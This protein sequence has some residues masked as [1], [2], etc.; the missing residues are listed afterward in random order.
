MTTQYSASRDSRRSAALRAREADQRAT[1][2]LAAIVATRT[3][4]R[5]G[6]VAE[7]RRP[8]SHR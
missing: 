8:G 7:T 4:V 5:S 3:P 1:A 6:M 2:T